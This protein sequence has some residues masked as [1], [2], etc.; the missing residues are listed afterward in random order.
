MGR[1]NATRLKGLAIK[2]ESGGV[3]GLISLLVKKLEHGDAETREVAC[4]Q[5]R[6]LAQQTGQLA[7]LQVWQSC[8]RIAVS[9]CSHGARARGSGSRCVRTSAASR[10]ASC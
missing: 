2:K 1:N 7:L 6:S 9:S 3:Q 10:G 4:A 8:R 5:L